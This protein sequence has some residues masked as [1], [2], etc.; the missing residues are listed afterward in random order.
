MVSNENVL[1]SLAEA[2]K[3]PYTDDRSFVRDQLYG[4]VQECRLVLQDRSSSPAKKETAESAY[5]GKM[6]RTSKILK[7]ALGALS[8]DDA[9]RMREKIQEI[10]FCLNVEDSMT[11]AG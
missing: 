5:E 4:C 10:C 6:G 1:D 11:D 2:M 3:L 9:Q 8:P 7:S